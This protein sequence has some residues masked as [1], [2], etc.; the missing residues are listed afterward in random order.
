MFGTAIIVFREVL[1]A[2]I[3]IGIV[4][5]A[6]RNVPGSRRWLTAGLLAGLVG[7]GMVAA[8]TDVIG[9]L[10]SGI[11]QEIFNAIVLG[12]AVLMLAWHNIW[13]SSHG[14]ALAASARSVGGD[15]RD[16]RSECS[17]LLFIVGLAVLREGSETVLFLYGIAASDGGRQSSMPLGGL[18]GML[19]GIAVGYTIYAGLLRVPMRWFFTTTAVLVLLLAAGMASQA[20]HFL[21]QADL[22]PSLAAP[23][24]DTSAALPENGLP[25]ILLHSLV[26]YDSHPAGMQLVFYLTVLV[27]ISIGMKW[28]A[29]PRQAVT[30]K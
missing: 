22:L 25:G 6:T 27:A 10:A 29:R 16:G 2:A 17:V 8:F 26:G 9:S 24:W 13:M 20:A 23:L 14:A 1:E 11:G 4:A 28:A 18:V 7:S 3:I 5:A 21:I 30:Q 15:I 19:L 12:I